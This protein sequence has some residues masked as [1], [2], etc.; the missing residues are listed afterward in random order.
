MGMIH[1]SKNCRV[2]QQLKWIDKT[3]WNGLNGKQR[4]VEG[5]WLWDRFQYNLYCQ[6][7]W[8]V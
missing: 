4:N 6:S 7:C 2:W 3:A 5:E 8:I 1:N